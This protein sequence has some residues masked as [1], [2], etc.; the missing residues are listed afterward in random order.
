MT[1]HPQTATE[2]FVRAA[3][4]GGWGE[5]YPKHWSLR[6][7]ACFAVENDQALLDPALWQAAGRSLGWSEE[8]TSA[9]YDQECDYEWQ[10]RWQCL[11]HWLAAHPGDVDG[12]L[13]GL[14]TDTKDSK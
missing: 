6:E 13:A 3:A 7:L 11:L 4:D 14:L 8:K 12:Y 1:D 9:Y 5:K 2:R 10:Y